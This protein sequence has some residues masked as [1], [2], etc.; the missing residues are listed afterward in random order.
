MRKMKNESNFF[1]IIYTGEEKT[2]KTPGEPFVI[3][4]TR[5]ELFRL[6]ERVIKDAR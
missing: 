6:N 5:I 3:F 1:T 2:K 4:I